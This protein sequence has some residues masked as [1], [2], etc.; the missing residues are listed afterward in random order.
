MKMMKVSEQVMKCF[1]VIKERNYL[2][3]VK[4]IAK[5]LLLNLMLPIITKPHITTPPHILP[6]SP[7]RM[8]YQIDI[9]H[10]IQHK[11][12]PPSSYLHINNVSAGT[13]FITKVAE[14]EKLDHGWRPRRTNTTDPEI[15]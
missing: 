10:Q 1:R 7:D 15:V 5:I 2:V 14:L 3:V 9:T 11:A 6:K 12:T 4:V 8:N 13:T